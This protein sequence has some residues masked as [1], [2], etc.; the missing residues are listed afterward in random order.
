MYD[1][2]NLGKTQHE[3]LWN[4]EQLDEICKEFETKMS[5][6]ANNLKFMAA[7]LDCLREYRKNIKLFFK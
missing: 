6:H 1:N 3:Y 7:Y 2:L 4:I 5:D